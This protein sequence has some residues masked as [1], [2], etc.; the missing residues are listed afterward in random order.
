MTGKQT[1]FE[2]NNDRF[3]WTS[4]ADTLI[5][6]WWATMSATE[7][8]RKLGTTKNSVIG[9]VRRLNLPQK[10]MEVIRR[11]KQSDIDQVLAL[12]ALNHPAAVIATL[13]ERT[14]ESV[15]RMAK[16]G[17]DPFIHPYKLMKLKGGRPTRQRSNAF[18]PT[19]KKAPI[20]MPNHVAPPVDLDTP[21]PLHRC[22]WL[23]GERKSYIQCYEA[24][25]KMHSNWC[26]PHY[27]LCYKRREDYNGTQA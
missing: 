7:I 22:T 5:T 3:I 25:G 1:D 4:F 15:R 14:P 23:Y 24:V 27:L 21:I 26:D 11:W 16:L 10:G 18:L 6:K 2:R 20:E 9:R 19:E 17:G 12:K 13:M 8:S